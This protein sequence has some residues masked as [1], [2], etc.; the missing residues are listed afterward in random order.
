MEPFLHG[1]LRFI[2]VKISISDAYFESWSSLIRQKEYSS[3]KSV[4]IVEKNY[5]ANILLPY[6][7]SK[8]SVNIFINRQLRCQHLISKLD[9]PISRIPNRMSILYECKDE[10]VTPYP[11]L[12]LHMILFE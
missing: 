12:N 10:I 2:F 7:W 3:K 4:L 11:Q 8:K 5:L 9:E 1:T 6:K